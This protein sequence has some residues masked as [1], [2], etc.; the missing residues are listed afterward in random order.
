M[1]DE[2]T[3]SGPLGRRLLEDAEEMR[4]SGYLVVDAIVDRWSRLDDGPAWQGATRDDQLDDV[5]AHIQST[6]VQS[7]FAMISSTRM[8]G[9]F[10]LR[11]CILNARTTAGDVG[12][13]LDRILELGREFAA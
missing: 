6:I 2:A 4:R 5:N 1:K 11:F 13:V 3:E 8:K 10:S 9:R 12:R 7:G